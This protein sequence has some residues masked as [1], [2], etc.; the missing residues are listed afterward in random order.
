MWTTLFRLIPPVL[1]F[2]RNVLPKIYVTSGVRKY[3]VSYVLS[4]ISNDDLN[5]RLK[6]ISQNI[7][8]KDELTFL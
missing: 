7:K 5:L 4:H 1:K 2:V 6:K 8:K 3:G